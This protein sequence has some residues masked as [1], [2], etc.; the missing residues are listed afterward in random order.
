MS[1]SSHGRRG[2]ARAGTFAPDI[3][4]RL[5]AA[6]VSARFLQIGDAGIVLET[7]AALSEVQAAVRPALVTQDN[8][9]APCEMTI[10]V[11][12]WVLKEGAT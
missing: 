3:A 9:Y 6:A 8:L 11:P 1:G 4:R 2:P 7:R 10:T 5:K 12:W